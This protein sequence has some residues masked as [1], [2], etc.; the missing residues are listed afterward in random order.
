MTAE[1]VRPGDEDVDEVEDG[2]GAVELEVAAAGGG[3]LEADADGAAVGAGGVEADVEAGVWA[4][5][6]AGGDGA[7]V[8]V[9]AGGLGAGVGEL[10]VSAGEPAAVPTSLVAVLTALVTGAVALETAPVTPETRE[11]GP[12]AEALAV[13]INPAAKAKMVEM[14]AKRGLPGTLTI[15]GSLPMLGTCKSYHPGGFLPKALGQASRLLGF[16]A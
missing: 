8:A 10:A 1:A 15:L 13:A 11:A 6:E 5:V 7:V 2:L 12:S 16:A 14:I 3:A 9:G 4:G